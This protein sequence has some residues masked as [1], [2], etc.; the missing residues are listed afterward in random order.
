M[1]LEID[2][3]WQGDTIVMYFTGMKAYKVTI[4]GLRLEKLYYKLQDDRMRAVRE[5]ARDF[6]AGDTDLHVKSITVE[7]LKDDD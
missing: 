3:T 5:A 2:M 1:H 6:D 4:K 7:E